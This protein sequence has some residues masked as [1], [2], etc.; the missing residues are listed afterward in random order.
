MWCRL[1]RHERRSL[2]VSPSKPFLADFKRAAA[3][4]AEL[5][6]SAFVTCATR[7][8]PWTPRPLPVLVGSSM[9]MSVKVATRDPYVAAFKGMACWGW[10]TWMIILRGFRRKGA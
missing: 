7:L 5:M 8:D 4:G 10:P 6:Q 2:A 3:S 9:A 1:P